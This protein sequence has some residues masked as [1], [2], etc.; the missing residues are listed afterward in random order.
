MLMLAY[1]G[2]SSGWTLLPGLY[3]V[4]LCRNIFPSSKLLLLLRCLW[5][6][7]DPA[8]D[9]CH[10]P[11]ADRNI[12]TYCT[13]Y[14]FQQQNDLLQVHARTERLLL[15]GFTVGSRRH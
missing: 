2:Q 3:V 5:L 1:S 8:G 13:Q 6:Q 9:L 7:T 14:S 11:G 4:L 15:L 10:N 12:Y